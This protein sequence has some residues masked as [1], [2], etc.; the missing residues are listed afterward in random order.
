MTQPIVDFSRKS[1]R[2]RRLDDGERELLEAC[3]GKPM[4]VSSL[5]T[6]DK[7]AAD[8]AIRFIHDGLMG[9]TRQ[10]SRVLVFTT[11]AGRDALAK[12]IKP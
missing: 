4:R 3:D 9:T 5:Q 8:T 10:G 11:Q 7:Y 2:Q 1:L 12:G 6:L